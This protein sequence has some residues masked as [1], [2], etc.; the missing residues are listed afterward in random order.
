MA[1]TSVTIR[2]DEDLKQRAERFLD[3]IG[4]NM[5]TAVTVFLKAALRK[6]RIPFQL[7]ADPFW[8]E[9]NQAH[10]RHAAALMD[11]GGH[12]VTKTLDE[13]EAMEND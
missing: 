5:T 13:L 10:L 3:D 8:S 2:L 12:A 7:E 6:G 1:S 11:S 4:M 9:E